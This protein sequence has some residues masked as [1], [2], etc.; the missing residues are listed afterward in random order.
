MLRLS[1]IGTG[2]CYRPTVILC[3]EV[4]LC[5]LVLVFEFLLV[6]GMFPVVRVCSFVWRC[7][8]GSL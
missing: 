3:G 6:V 4:V 8:L 5:T 7:P 2:V 1:G